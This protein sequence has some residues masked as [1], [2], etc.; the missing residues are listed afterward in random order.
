MSPDSPLNEEA[1]CRHPD[2]L[3]AGPSQDRVEETTMNRAEATETTSKK[4]N[5]ITVRRI[6]ILL[7]LVVLGLVPF[8]W[9]QVLRRAEFL[10]TGAVTIDGH[11]IYL[12]KNDQVITQ[13]IL[14]WGTWETAE[15]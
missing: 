8:H 3:A 6:N 9:G 4:P 13:N 5:P 14:R 12:D 10:W 1:L 11:T 7:A 2:Q 15:T